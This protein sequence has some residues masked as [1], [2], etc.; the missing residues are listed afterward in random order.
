MF[1]NQAAD[2]AAAIIDPKRDRVIDAIRAYGLLGVIGGHL[3][4][5]VVL[6]SDGVPILSNTLSSSTSLQALTWLLQ[7]M[8]LFFIAGGSANLLSWN[9]AQHKQTPYIAWAWQRIQRLLKP[10]GAYLLVMIPLG[11][12]VARVSDSAISTPLLNLMTQLLWFLGIYILITALTPLYI[13]LERKLGRGAVGMWL[14]IVALTDGLRHYAQTPEFLSLLNFISVWSIAAH[15]G[16][17]YINRTFNRST[18][19]SFLI[20]AFGLNLVLVKF[21]PYP[22]SLV[23]MPGETFSNMA[24]PSLVMALH[25]V[26]CWSGLQLL[27]NRLTILTNSFKTWRLIVAV[28]MSAMTIYLWHLPVLTLLTVLSHQLGWDRPLTLDAL[29]RVEPGMNFWWWSLLFWIVCAIAIYGVVQVLWIT[30][31][32]KLRW[33]DKPDTNEHPS[34]FAK[35]IAYVSIAAIGVGLLLISGSGLAGFPNRLVEFSGIAWTSGF[36]VSVLISGVFGLRMAISAGRSSH[37]PKQ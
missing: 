1:L 6:W 27:K 30:E 25:T 10:M 14:G 5:G 28:N 24:P 26:I 7:I 2:K 11:A 17:W 29:N 4:M 3:T 35:L 23:G 21:G 13:F 32:F 18:L 37:Q 19:F 20:I 22:I 15:L 36:A 33:W 9:S 34:V 16:I 31:H 8:P 12:G